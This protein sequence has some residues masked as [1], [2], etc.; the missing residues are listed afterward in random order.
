MY[1]YFFFFYCKLL[2]NYPES[3]RYFFMVQAHPRSNGTRGIRTRN[4]KVMPPVR[5]DRKTLKD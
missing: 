5:S 2:M 4:S 3:G 1:Q